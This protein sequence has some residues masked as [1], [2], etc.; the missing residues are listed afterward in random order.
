M[1]NCFWF[2]CSWWNWTINDVNIKLLTCCCVFLFQLLKHESFKC[3][4]IYKQIQ[5]HQYMVEHYQYA[6]YIITARKYNGLIAN[7]SHGLSISQ[8]SYK[9]QKL[10]VY[11]LN[12]F[13]S[14]LSILCEIGFLIICACSRVNVFFIYIHAYVRT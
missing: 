8:P 13:L 6:L 12:I 11:C 10:V 14:I 4:C 7:I 2:T 3:M 9:P 5:L 1:S